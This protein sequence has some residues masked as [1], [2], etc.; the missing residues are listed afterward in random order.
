PTPP[1]TDP[2]DNNRIIAG[3]DPDVGIAAGMFGSFS[4]AP[5]VPVK[6]ED[7][8]RVFMDD[9]T[10]QIEKGSVF[11]EELREINMSLGMEYWYDKQFALRVGYFHE[12]SSKGNRKF[13]TFGAGLKYNVFG[14]DLAYIVPT[15]Q[16]HPL[17]NTLRF[18]LT[19]NFAAVKSDKGSG[20]L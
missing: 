1:I 11:K 19:M 20:N 17:A 13:V 15:V 7:G 9:G 5:G 2:L 4:D 6:D 18:T 12:H 3:S 14:L 16:R 8:N 10:L